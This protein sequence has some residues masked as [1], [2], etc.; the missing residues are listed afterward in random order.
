MK[1]GLPRSRRLRLGLVVRLLALVGAIAVCLL[2]AAGSA[3]ASSLPPNCRQGADFVAC[4]FNYTGSEQTFTV[5]SG[6]DS[7]EVE[8]VGAAGGRGDSSA[9]GGLGSMALALVPV[10]PGQTLYVEVGGPG[11]HLPDLTG[12]GGWNG[13]S[14]A[15]NGAGSGGGASDVRTLSCGLACPG[16]AVSLASRLVVAA[17]G[18]GGATG[19]LAGA[20]GAGDRAGEDAVGGGAGGGPGTLSTGGV[21]GAGAP[22]CDTSIAGLPGDNGAFGQGGA[23]ATPSMTV[24][25]F[26]GGGGGGYFGGGAG[27]SGVSTT[28]YCVS[29]GGSGGTGSGGPFNGGGGGGGGSSYAP[30]GT[31]EPAPVGVP[32]SV[33][34]LYGAEAST[35][36]Q[37]L[38]FAGQQQA[39]L[40]GSQP[41]TVTNTGITPL[42]VSGL[43]F[44]GTD[45]ADFVVTS[46]DC[47][48]TAI[49]PGASCIVNVSFA[50]QAQGSRS[51]TLVIASN[52]PLTPATVAL[53]GTGSAPAAGPQGPVGDTGPQGPAGTI[54]PAGATGPQGPTGPQGATGP[55]GPPG[56]SGK[57]ICND[58]NAARVL[59]S[60]IFKPGTWSTNNAPTVASFRISHQGRTIATGKVAIRHGRVT[61]RS[62]RLRPGRYLLTVT[63]G[64]GPRKLTITRKIVNIEVHTER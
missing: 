48:G 5:P 18:G 6:V 14:G 13:G 27:G 62:P 54:G 8:T 10:R 25:G 33:T 34:I 11:H 37:A 28:G 57:L 22:A 55:Q 46:D 32:A 23:A 15:P 58:T 20:G 51:A 30:G 21:G 31:I 47:R 53:S 29:R 59:C 52:D 1:A 3:L 12:P 45:A 9:P 36:P 40:S 56:P 39:T 7:V 4:P 60:I 64:T 42:R 38:T 16:D 24:F 63:I 2:A 49:D 43:T 44:S 50:P 41:V 26:G 19:P 17:G 35:S 61:V